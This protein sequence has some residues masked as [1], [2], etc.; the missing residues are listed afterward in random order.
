MPIGKDRFTQPQLVACVLMLYRLAIS[1]RDMEEWLM[2]SDQVCQ[3]LELAHIPDH[4]TLSR[5]MKR[6]RQQDWLRLN[7]ELLRRVG[8][9]EEEVAG[10]S[11]SFRLTQASAY[12]QTRTGRT[13]TEWEK[14]AYA[15]GL[16]SR[17]ILAMA[18]GAGSRP[19]FGFLRI[20]KR[21]VARFGRKV[22][23]ERAWAFLADA[24]FDSKDVTDKDIIP[25]IRRNG[26]LV[27]PKR[28]A[29]ADLV[30]AARLDGLYGQRWLIETVNS[31]IKRLFGD[32][33]RSRS[34]LLRRR[35]TLI[36][37][38]VYNIHV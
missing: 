12:Y 32:S 37:A 2:A 31:V 25:P 21:Q 7:E 11:T 28:K 3:V 26:K 1:Y 18:S 6:M 36:K 24:G 16:K 19:D 22:G 35:E 34:R 10:D 8:V 27:D 13:Y 5:M 17:L 9:E 29:R 14:G 4:S 33:V 23:A 30:S 38:I 20:L 15:V